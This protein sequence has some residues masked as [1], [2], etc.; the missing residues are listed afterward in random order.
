MMRRSWALW[1]ACASISALGACDGRPRPAASSGSLASIIPQVEQE[2]ARGLPLEGARLLASKLDGLPDAEKGEAHAVLARLYSRGNANQRC[3]ESATAARAA[4]SRRAEVLYL[5]GEARRR[6]HLPGALEVLEQALAALPEHPPTL[7]ALARLRFRSP[8]PRSALPLFEKYFRLASADDPER[9]QALL[10]HGRALRETGSH[11]EA[12]DLFVTCLEEK[13]LESILYSELASTLYRMRLRKEARFVEEIYKLISQSSFEDQVE[14]RLL[15]SGATAFALGQRAVNATRQR[16]FLEAF[17]SYR[18]ALSLDASEPRLRTFYA[19]LCLHFRRFAEAH[20]VLDGALA[21]RLE[22]SSGL[23]WMKGR[24]LLEKKDARAALEAFRAAREALRKE[25]DAG[26]QEKGQA[27]LFSVLMAGARSGVE[28]GALDA[29]EEAAAAG[30]KLVPGGWEPPFWRGRALLAR[31]DSGAALSSFEEASRRGGQGISDV[32]HW[33]AVALDAS[34]RRAEALAE[35]EN[36][37]RAQP[38]YTPAYPVLARLSADDP[39]RAALWSQAE[40]EIASLEAERDALAASLGA[41]PLEETGPELLEM[42]KLL[43]R[44]KSPDHADFLF[45]AAEILPSS[46]ETHRLIVQGLKGSQDVFVRLRH[47]KKILALEAGDDQILAAI[48]EVYSKLHVHL[49]EAERLAARAHEIKP[50]AA[51]WR[52]RGEAAIL[53]GDVE[54]GKALLRDGLAAFPGDKGLGEALA[55]AE[56]PGASP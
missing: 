1:A 51:S 5:E 46:A 39:S 56:A 40:G 45:L 15:Q 25:G 9:W 8:E 3:L 37:V 21:A 14:H 16:D 31:G 38:G 7:L 22:P 13:P 24:V 6:L 32:R 4:G 34:G 30:E 28:S 27:P 12:A 49:D 20:A 47:L 2:E 35:L 26:G 10:E 33:R 48:A 52:L 50:S 41:K 44:L 54:K 42:G 29:A 19:D 17:R 36:V 55:R 18:Q 11:Q 43:R 53:K 23:L